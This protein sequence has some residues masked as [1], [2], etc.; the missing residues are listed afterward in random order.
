[1]LRS[2]R[3]VASLIGSLVFGTVLP[4]T[5]TLGVLV[6][7]GCKDESQP[8]YWVEKLSEPTWRSRAIS[9]FDQFFEDAL[10]RSNK[11][12]KSQDVQD[13]INK[14]VEPL[15]KAYVEAADQLDPKSRVTLIKLLSGYKDKRAEPAFKKAFE[16]FAKSPR[17]S[18][19]DQDLKWAAIAAGDLRLESLAGPMVEAFAKFR[20]STMLGGV[21]YKDFN[22]ALLDMPSKSWTQP[23]ISKLEA[24][25]RKPQGKAD[26]SAVGDY[27]DQQF[28]QTTAAALL[29]RIGDPAAVEPLIRVILDPA[30]VDFH[31]TAMVALIQLGKPSTDAAVKLLKNQDE[32]LTA[33]CQ[34]RLKETGWDGKGKP[35]VQTA[36]VIIGS[37]GRPDGAPAM[38]EVLKTENDD[39]TKA[40]IARELSKLPASAESIAAFKA[41]YES[42]PLSAQ[43]PP[44]QPALEILTESAGQVFD[45]SLVEWLLGRAESIKA[46]KSE[47]DEKKSLQLAILTTTI[48]LAKP[49]QVPVV[50]KAVN[51]YGTKLE[52]DLL[53]QAEELLKACGD[54]A[55]C[56]VEALQKR[57]NQE[58]SAQFVGIKAGYM[59]AEFGDEATRDALV[60]RLDS[61]NN[62][63]LRFVASQVVDRLSPKGSKQSVEKMNAIIEKNAKSP[64]RDKAL[65]DAPLKQVMYRLSARGG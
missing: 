29:G 38:I 7:S 17:T 27:M 34:R 42:L 35:C 48:K 40:V 46:D 13:L 25:V 58:R 61:I 47:A 28:W 44:G 2:S 20:A 15:T 57:E 10:T 18:K 63:A 19:D 16:D 36:A 43:I 39:A 56:Y 65:G 59:A 30:R 23:L 33:Y 12:L 24:E 51:S 60:S 22:A 6:V 5:V 54:R 55:P 26:P 53:A 31:Q 62:A 3:S 64:D 52:K 21:V 9:R 14:T 4:T 1:M 50:K 45:A 49:D 32:K 8:E 41:A 37:V 11:D